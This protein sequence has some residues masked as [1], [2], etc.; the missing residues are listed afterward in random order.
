MVGFPSPTARDKGL[1]PLAP[2]DFATAGS[3][4]WGLDGRP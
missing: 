1:K 4:F 3:G 2:R